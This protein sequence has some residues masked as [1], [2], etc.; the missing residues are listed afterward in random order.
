MS[1]VQE[2]PAVS[3][4]DSVA[5][6][7]SSISVI[8]SRR[9][10]AEQIN[11]FEEGD[12]VVLVAQKKEETNPIQENDLFNMGTLAEISHIKNLISGTKQILFRCIQRFRIQSIAFDNGLIVKG[13]L[14]RTIVEDN[15]IIDAHKD[16]LFKRVKTWIRMQN[17]STENSSLHSSFQ[18]LKKIESAE[19]MLDILVGHTGMPVS[20]K[21]SILA[22]KSLE[23]RFMIACTFF[24]DKVASIKVKERIEE[25]L[26]ELM[27]KKQKEYLDQLKSE[28]IKDESD[29][30]DEWSELEGRVKK[31]AAPEEVEKKA[32]Y[33]LKKMSSMNPSS[34]EASVIRSYLDWICDLPWSK[35]NPM[36]KSLTNAELI[37]DQ[38]HYGLG[39]IKEEIIKYIA[40]YNRTQKPQGSVLCL[41]GPPG[42][43]KTSLGQSIAKATKRAFAR[44]ALGGVRDEAEIRG[45][46]RTYVGAMP[47]KI[48]QELKRCGSNNP[49]FMLDEI[50]KIGQDW[51]GD[52]SSALL[53]VLDPEQNHSFADHYL[54][55]PFSLSNCMFICTANTTQT[56]PSA[57][58]DRMD[59]IHISSYTEDEKIDIAEKHLLPRQRDIACLEKKEFDISKE[60]I[61]T[62]IRDYTREAG[63][64][65]LSR[66]ISSLARK[67]VMLIDGQKKDA[68][69]ITKSNI[70]KYSG[71]PKYLRDKTR[72]KDHI[73]VATGMAWTEFGGDTLLIESVLVPGKGK[74]IPTGKLGDVM[75]ESVHIAFSFLRSHAAA[76]RIDL[77]ILENHDV[78]VHVPEGATPKDGPSA[79]VAIF[80]SMAS[81][82]LNKPLLRSVAMTGEISLTGR[83]W[84]VGGIKEKILS[85]HRDNIPT[86]L[87]PKEN[88]HN[89]EEIPQSVKNNINI[90]TIDHARQALCYAIEGYAKESDQKSLQIIK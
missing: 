15:V 35:Q 1:S 49:L 2:Y 75:K 4:R 53:E 6:P 67:A 17:K 80:L 81:T 41:V 73:G 39:K 54:E 43:G 40:V 51:R 52:P 27:S 70:Q 24:Q 36:E 33:E 55:S 31:A 58:L 32:L 22:A 11:Q 76:Q 56:I 34:S 29:D 83:V 60:A 3:L 85:A 26:A 61:R 89:L 47:G 5:M 42:V 86:V 12:K 63:V 71:I 50:D 74:V 7:C 79:G 25:R 59:I 88:T 82:L 69:N 90:V 77:S 19:K 38:E 62:M 65:S 16:I 48:L 37:L 30:R 46:R 64:R 68:V 84:P 72:K 21:Q 66:M 78:H 18:S 9:Q 20:I 45:H 8:V 28:V 13:L 10:F 44:I 23:R 87:I 57:L 14:S